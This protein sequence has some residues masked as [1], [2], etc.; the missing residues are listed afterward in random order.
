M[1][2]EMEKKSETLYL[3]L[4]LFLRKKFMGS[5]DNGF[6]LITIFYNKLVESDIKY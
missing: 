6:I 2:F 5:M 3:L 4:F 1:F